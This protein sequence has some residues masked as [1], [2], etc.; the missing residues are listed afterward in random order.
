MRSDWALLAPSH[1]VV[2]IFATNLLISIIYS[3]HISKA[4]RP[5]F[6]LV[7]TRRSFS[8]YAGRG[9]VAAIRS[10]RPRLLLQYTR[11]IDS[12][13]PEAAILKLIA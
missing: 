13:E 12:T 10:A 3:R 1:R 11:L 6:I 8:S 7:K 9:A 2:N 4:I 5:R